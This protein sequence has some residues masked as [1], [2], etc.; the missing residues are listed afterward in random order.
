M[1]VP[2]FRSLKRAIIGGLVVAAAAGAAVATAV[3]R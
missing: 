3:L 2:D 1:M